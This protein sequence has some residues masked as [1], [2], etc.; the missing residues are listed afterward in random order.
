MKWLED[1]AVNPKNGS[2]M[3][4]VADLTGR[5]IGGAIEA[6]GYGPKEDPGS[7]WPGPQSASQ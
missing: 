4:A 1:C 6:A 3:E 7:A 5:I 2:Y